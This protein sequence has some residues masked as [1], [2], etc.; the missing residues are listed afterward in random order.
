MPLVATGSPYLVTPGRVTKDDG[1]PYKVFTPFLRKW[2]KA[3]WRKPAQSSADSARWLDPAGVV[4]QCTLPDPGTELGFDAGEA[5]ALSQWKQFADGGLVCYAQERD[6][7]D[8]PGTSR[9]SAHLKLGTIHPEPWWR[10]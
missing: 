6:R 2:R 7:P 4:K 3:G 10:R 5:A 9:M 1:E 8:L